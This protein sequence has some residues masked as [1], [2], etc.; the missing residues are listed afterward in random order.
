[1]EILK[2]ELAKIKEENQEKYGSEKDLTEF[3]TRKQY[4]DIYLE[5]IGW[6][7]YKDWTEEVAASGL[8]SQD[9]YRKLCGTLKYYRKG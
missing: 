6:Q 4:I 7:K 8:S 1:M 2:K 5:E 9:Y 3:E